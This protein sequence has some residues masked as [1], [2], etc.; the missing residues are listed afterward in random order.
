MLLQRKSSPQVSSIR[1]KC[2]CSSFPRRQHRARSVSKRQIIFRT[3]SLGT[4][5]RRLIDFLLGYQQKQEDHTN[6]EKHLSLVWSVCAQNSTFRS[7]LE[8]F[9]KHFVHNFL[10]RTRVKSNFGTS[11][12]LSCA[13][14]QLP[15]IFSSR[16]F[17]RRSGRYPSDTTTTC[18]STTHGRMVI[19][20]EKATLSTCSLL[21]LLTKGALYS[22]YVWRFT[23]EKPF[24]LITV[25]K[26]KRK[27]SKFL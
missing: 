7:L 9:L 27:S 18:T 23:G 11:W 15:S 26:R 2:T 20:I 19:S 17:T 14:L 13:A 8:F 1:E 3:N 5:C 21:Q 12:Q 25:G 4:F 6:D 22:E 24:E 10:P 16:S